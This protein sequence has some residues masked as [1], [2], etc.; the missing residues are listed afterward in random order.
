MGGNPSVSKCLKFFSL[1]LFMK[2]C[3]FCVFCY[4]KIEHMKENKERKQKRRREEGKKE[5]PGK[6]TQAIERVIWL[7]RTRDGY[8]TRV[9]ETLRGSVNR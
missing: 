6:I 4:K 2:T 3:I 5:A 1:I 7:Y 9:I 8:I